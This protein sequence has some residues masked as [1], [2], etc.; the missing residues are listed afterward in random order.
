[1]LF[2]YADDGPDHR[3]TYLSVQLSLIALFLKVDLDIL[4][5]GR[6]APSNSWANPMEKIMSIVYLGLQSIGIMRAEM[7]EDFEKTVA[8]CSSLK[9]IRVGCSS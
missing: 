8:N 5:A 3:L 7:G 9:K 6:T 2:L 4:V 1:M